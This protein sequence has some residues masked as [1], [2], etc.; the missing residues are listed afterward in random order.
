[1]C[2]A[3]IAAIITALVD[4]KYE[5][6]VEVMIDQKPIGGAMQMST[7][8]SSVSDLVDFMRPRSLATTV[9]QMVAFGVVSEACR[10]VAT[11]M[12]RPYAVGDGNPLD[13]AV[14]MNSIS[15][16]AEATSDIVGIRIRH[17][18]PTVAENLAREIPNAF[19]K[20]NTDST[21]ALAQ[22][23]ILQL[24]QALVPLKTELVTIDN[25]IEKLRAEAGTAD[26]GAQVQSDIT[27]LQS[28]RTQKEQTLME[29]A[30]ARGK[31][32]RIQSEYDSL[33]KD[34]LLAQTEQPNP[35]LQKYQ[36]DLAAAKARLA[37]L[38]ERYTEE[39]EEVIASKREVW[40]LMD[41]IKTEPKTIRSQSTGP[42]E[43]GRVLRSSAAEAKAV[44][45]GL[46]QRLTAVES[47]IQQAESSQKRF[48]ELQKKL[49][50]ASREQDSL[51]RLV[52]GY[53]DRLTSLK[54]VGIG[55]ISPV[56]EVTKAFVFPEPV[57]PK[58]LINILF[59]LTAGLILGVLSML[60]TEAK[61]QPVRSLAQLN[62]LALKPIYRIVP[63]LRQP[64]RGLS[65]APA[66]AFDSL[67]AN[68]LRSQDRPYRVAVVGVTKDS[69][70]STSAIN[71][72]IA[73]SR[74]GAR[75]L[76][77]Q[78]DPKGGASR[79]SGKQPPASGEFQEISSLIKVTSA[80][81]V[82]QISTDRN[83]EFSADI[84]AHEAELTIIDLE[85]TTRSAEYA[86]LAPHVDEVILLVRAGRAKSVEFLQAQQ[87][88]K[89]SGCKTVTVCFT[90]ASDLAVV[91][92]S[93]DVEARPKSDPQLPAE[94]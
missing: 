16:S 60:A 36:G 51:Q 18:E 83:P 88:L 78:C 75:V 7:A 49:L 31:Y 70:A 59:G 68:Y 50:Q 35:L 66:E 40:A 55:R 14:V 52:I 20:Q 21:R 80:E 3:V 4:R 81:S 84:K 92:E 73:G 71:L 26:L 45:D 28:L 72:A 76:L 39:R 23:A 37:A 65:K 34:Q 47:S 6:V 77:I 62:A 53:T 63:E 8:E 12:N 64:Y 19:V 91:T 5:A 1:M 17:K 10:Q 46:E 54:A 85:P 41:L 93:V 58:P 32:A 11:Q 30:N 48:P 67:L 42:N 27:F 79:L 61:R 74:H 13:P 57:S 43:V 89:E 56:R 29:L 33:V 90:R 2:G 82:L 15:V 38:R 87:A 86:F 24:T 9:Q 94:A 44:V 22:Q 69:G 25:S